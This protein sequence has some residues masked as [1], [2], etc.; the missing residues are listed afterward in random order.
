[1]KIL[2]VEDEVNT[3]E[4]LAM[5]I[6]NLCPDASVSLAECG[7]QAIGLCSTR[8][9]DLIFTDIRMPGMNGFQMLSQLDRKGRMLGIVSGYADVSYAQQAIRFSVL[10]YVLKPV[11]VTRIRA[12]LQT[13]CQKQ[14]AMKSGCLY[15][16][17]TSYKELSDKNRAYCW[18]KMDL[19]PISGLFL[20]IP[21]GNREPGPCVKRVR[22]QLMHLKHQQGLGI[23]SVRIR[24]WQYLVLS[25][26]Q[27]SLL[28]TA[29]REMQ[30][31]LGKEAG[32]VFA[33]LAV[34]GEELVELYKASAQKQSMYQTE[35]RN[36]TVQLVKEFIEQNLDT[37]ISLAMLAE[38]AYMH[39]S[40]LSA[41]FKKETGQNLTDYI[42]NC[43]IR[44]A[45][46]LLAHPHYKIYE[47]ASAV[48]YGDA[49]YFSNVFKTAT[50]MT[51]R[52]WRMVRPARP[53][54]S[55]SPGQ[56]H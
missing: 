24:N 2:I 49:K 46:E 33:G 45:M 15:N 8:F 20:L 40:Y 53:E 13:A 42:V 47:V 21:E 22:E 1:M 11:S 44:R 43:R 12:V 4:G 55:D 28:K 19:G 18:E 27:E 36:Q 39:P 51:P 35:D 5:L 3:R 25:G 56:K 31:A 17:L 50:G 30:Q 52:E 54:Q 6:G 9:Y 32:L 23:L 34:S 48:G 16:Y 38:V 26:G 7:Q 41:L 37:S 29:E 14:D 10:D